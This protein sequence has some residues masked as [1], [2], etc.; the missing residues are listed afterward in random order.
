MLLVGDSASRS[1][2]AAGIDPSL[3]AWQ[4]RPRKKLFP[5]K[6]DCPRRDVAGRTVERRNYQR[7]ASKSI[8]RRV[9]RSMF[10]VIEAK[11]T[12]RLT[13][14]ATSFTNQEVIDP[15]PR[16][17]TSPFAE[18]RALAK[19]RSSSER[20]L[21]IPKLPGQPMRQAIFPAWAVSSD[22]AGHDA[23]RR[24]GQPTNDGHIVEQFLIMGDDSSFA[25]GHPASRNANE[26]GVRIL[27]AEVGACRIEQRMLLAQG[28]RGLPGVLARQRPLCIAQSAKR[29][30][31]S[32]ELLG[33]GLSPRWIGTTCRRIRSRHAGSEPP[34]DG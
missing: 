31:E 18:S 7:I 2:R 12:K 6:F 11:E 19:H 33:I 29:R 32:A 17:R 5:E 20:S 30:P 1:P 13:N 8:Y 4:G 14:R 16:D 28:F 9:R 22:R 34:A 15:V 21:L 26:E 23:S 24:A 25:T 27:P 10:A 3:R